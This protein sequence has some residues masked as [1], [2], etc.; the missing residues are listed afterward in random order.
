MMCK[1]IDL[2]GESYIRISIVMSRAFGIM[3]VFF[4]GVFY[5]DHYISA[6]KFT[7]ERVHIVLLGAQNICEYG[8]PTLDSINKEKIDRI[9][10]YHH[11]HSSSNSKCWMG[12]AILSVPKVLNVTDYLWTEDWEYTEKNALDSIPKY[13]QQGTT[14]LLYVLIYDGRIKTIQN[15]LP[16]IIA[17]VIVVITGA[18]FI[19]LSVII[20]LICYARKRYQLRLILRQG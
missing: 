18:C 17:P 2:Q 13:L 19:V 12:W 1:K 6:K 15:H 20:Y 3:L 16:D 14:P 9:Y 4:G 8:I 11:Q 7:L 5:I 10:L